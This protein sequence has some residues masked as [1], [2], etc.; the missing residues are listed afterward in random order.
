M[1]VNING[2]WNANGSFSLNTPLGSKKRWQLRTYSYLQYSN[3]NGYTTLKKQDP[4]E[5][6]VQHFTGRERLRLIYRT[7]QFEVGGQGEVLYNNSYNNI[8][9]QRTET[10]DYRFGGNVQWFLKWGFELYSDFTYRLRQGYG[11]NVGR[12]TFLW[13]M[14]LTK[15]FLKRKQLLL[16]FKV[17]DILHQEKSLERVIS[18][19][20][21]R[22]NEYNVLGSY[23]MIH[24]IFRLNIMGK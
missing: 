15:S 1:P 14:Q 21:I 17:Y 2:N 4:V 9:D 23:F 10:Y 3:R 12:E 20:S 24:A 11:T 8:R 16:R 13:N 6:S 5:T 22:D 7:S 18:A 19:S